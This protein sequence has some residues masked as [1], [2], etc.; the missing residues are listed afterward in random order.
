MDIREWLAAS[1]PGALGFVGGM[2]FMAA[3]VILIGAIH[4]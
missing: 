3:L 4:K 2:L 1:D